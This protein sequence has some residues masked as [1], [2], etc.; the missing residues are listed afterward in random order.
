MHIKRNGLK[1]LSILCNE[2]TDMHTHT[3]G[4][5]HKKKTRESRKKRILKVLSVSQSVS[6][7]K[8]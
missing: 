2:E 4:N 1:I 5:T 3:Y 6:Q 8:N 7:I